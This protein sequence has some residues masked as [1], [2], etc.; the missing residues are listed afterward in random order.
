MFS[1]G[2][3]TQPSWSVNA[4]LSSCPTPTISAATI[5]HLHQ[6]SALIPPTEGTQE[7]EKLTREMEELVRL[8]E[9]VKLK[10]IGHGEG[11]PDGRVWAGGK[12]IRLD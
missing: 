3:P 1:C 9:A 8:V 4:L 6:L 2:I 5:K 11:V 7:H 10:E 12:G